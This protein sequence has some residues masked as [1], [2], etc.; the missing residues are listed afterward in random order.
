MSLSIPWLHDFAWV[1]YEEHHSAVSKMIQWSEAEELSHKNVKFLLQVCQKIPCTF[2]HSRIS[3]LQ[4]L[5]T[6]LHWSTFHKMSVLPCKFCQMFLL[7][8]PVLHSVL[9]WTQE[10]DI[11]YSGRM[12]CICILFMIH[13]WI[14]ITPCFLNFFSQANIN[15]NCMTM[16]I[17]WLSIIFMEKLRKFNMYLASK[18]KIYQGK[19]S[20]GISYQFW[21]NQ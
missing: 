3:H 13:S 15:K 20:V 21:F 7:S 6:T 10:N 1:L 8:L 2:H 9:T 14:S 19:S 12:F 17:L 4:Q 11:R 5:S 16:V 18:T